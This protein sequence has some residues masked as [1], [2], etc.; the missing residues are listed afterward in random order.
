[1]MSENGK[2]ITKMGE[3]E[4]K[5]PKE[6]SLMKDFSAERVQEFIDKAPPEIAGLFLKILLRTT[7]IA[8]KMS[9]AMN[10]PADEKIKLGEQIGG[11]V[12]DLE[13]LLEKVKEETKE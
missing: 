7:T 10:L 11:L 6:F 3:L 1:M 4:K 8:P 2:L 12:K 9:N 13:A 5:Y